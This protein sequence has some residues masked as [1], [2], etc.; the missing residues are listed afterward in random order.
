MKA[1]EDEHQSVNKAILIP[2][3]NSFCDSEI[4]LST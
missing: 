1:N 4:Y 3:R 2:S